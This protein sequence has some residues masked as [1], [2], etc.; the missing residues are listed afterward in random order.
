MIAA[1]IHDY[2]MLGAPMHIETG[3]SIGLLAFK[4]LTPE[5]RYPIEMPGIKHGNV[6]LTPLLLTVTGEFGGRN[7]NGVSYRSY[8]LWRLQCTGFI[9][10][11][12]WS[13]VEWHSI[14]SEDPSLIR[15][16]PQKATED[17]VLVVIPEI[18][19]NFDS[20]EPQTI[21]KMDEL[22]GKTNKTITEQTTLTEAAMR[23]ILGKPIK[24]SATSV[25][26]IKD[27]S[28]IAFLGRWV[29]ERSIWRMLYLSATT[30]TT[31]GLGDIV[32]VT[33]RARIFL[34]VESIL[35]LA[36]MGCFINGVFRRATEDVQ[37]DS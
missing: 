16:F 30:I 9:K 18:R 1:R 36:L 35:G 2:N 6:S 20:V 21:A 12:F 4:Q 11:A 32:P 34:T 33:D 22:F 25:Q 37:I 28:D 26:L 7:E 15:D 13:Q 19:I 3:I 29:N 14:T 31:L 23:A 5:F 27:Y 8:G 10:L 17:R 24:L